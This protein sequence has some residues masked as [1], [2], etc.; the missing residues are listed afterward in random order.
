MPS[1]GGELCLRQHLVSAIPLLG[2]GVWQRARDMDQIKGDV[3]AMGGKQGRGQESVAQG[4]LIWT[5]QQGRL[6]WGK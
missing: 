1:T 4:S 3:S 5:G 6:L 2:E